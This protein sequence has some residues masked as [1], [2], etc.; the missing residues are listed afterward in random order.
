MAH[1][2]L[3][4]GSYTR[5][6]PHV[7]HAQG[8]GI[9]AL[10]FDTDAGTLRPLAVHAGP[11]NPTFLAAHPDGKTLYAVGEVENGTLS[12]FEVGSQGALRPLGAQPTEGGAPVQVDLGASGRFAYAVNYAGGKSIVAFPIL[13][14]G[15]LGPRAAAA[16][17]VGKG[18][19]AARQEGPHPHGVQVSPDGRHVYVCDLGT[20]EVV[21]YAAPS[22]D[23]ALRRLNALR[24]PPGGG[25]RHLTLHPSGRFAYAALELGSAVAA[26]GRDAESGALDLRQVLPA[27]PQDYAGENA[28]AEVLV[29][30][31]G[32]FVYVTNRGHDSVAV[33]AADGESGALTNLAFV[34]ALGKTPRSAVLS[35]DGG[36]L[37][38]ANQDSSTIAVFRRDAGT[39]ELS[40]GVTFACSTPAGLC[41]L[42]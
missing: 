2:L 38:V 37:L 9:A 17:H 26:L 16:E 6:E 27:Q 24:L 20:D 10:D 11:A 19:N 32:R 23:G 40:G 4:V 18:P 22:A 3:F 29:S 21:T 7:P 8:R 31:D 39:G 5:P 34:R 30:A 42:P 13:P 41:F 33:F 1:H 36:H 15:S 14:D 28:P 25:P 12:A 35:P